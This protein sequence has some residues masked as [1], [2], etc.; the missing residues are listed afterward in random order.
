[1]TTLFIASSLL[2]S[3]QALRRLA[4]SAEVHV[5]GDGGDVEETAALA[6]PAQVLLVDDEHLLTALEEGE[7]RLLPAVVLLAD[8]P[9]PAAI[10]RLRALE[11]PGWAVLQTGA[12][13][14]ELRAAIVAAGS[15]LAAMPAAAS[16]AAWPTRGRSVGLA[17]EREEGAGISEEALTSREH[18]VLGLVGLGL[19]NREIAA[20]LGISEHTAKFHVASVLAK[21]GAHNRVE[22]VRRGIR[23]GLVAV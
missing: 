21:L 13:S 15:G 8:E 2:A 22:A 9:G 17:D 6:E 14:S 1:M 3:R 5:V 23:R 19:S 16:T 10:D 4:A 12:T 11:L 20:R 7:E 18:E